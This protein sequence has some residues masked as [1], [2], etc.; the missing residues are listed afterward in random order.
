MNKRY[1]IVLVVMIFSLAVVSQVISRS[2]G[3][4]LY[5]QFYQSEIR[6]T[7]ENTSGSTGTT[8][9]LIGNIEYG[10]YPKTNTLNEFKIFSRNAKAGDSIIKPA[11]TDT[12]MLIKKNKVYLYT[13]KKFD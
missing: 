7:L 9:F 12:L 13:F 5:K 3:R 11:Y 8:Y 2:K 4:K 6:G 10:F 1:V